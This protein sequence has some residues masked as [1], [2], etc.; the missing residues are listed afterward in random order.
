MA[1]AS[2]KRAGNV[3]DMAARAMQTPLFQ[4]PAHDFEHVAWEF[5]QFVE[6]K[7]FVVCQ[8]YLARPRDSSPTDQAGVGDGVMRRAEGPRPDQAGASVEYAPTL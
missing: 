5:R 2:M 4:R 1:A 8:R 7:Y 6:K 3:R